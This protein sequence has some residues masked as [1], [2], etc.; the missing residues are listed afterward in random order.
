MF[1]GML[2]QVNST[3]DEKMQFSSFVAFFEP[4]SKI[5]V[6]VADCETQTLLEY[7]GNCC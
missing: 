4:H 2:L 1:E 3:D 6:P 5:Q 7:Q